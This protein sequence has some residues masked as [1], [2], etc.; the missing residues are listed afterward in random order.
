MPSSRMATALFAAPRNEIRLETN[1]VRVLGLAEKLWERCGPAGPGGPPIHLR[2]DVRPGGG[3]GPLP[4]KEI[5]WDLGDEEYAASVA[6]VLSLRIALPEARVNAQLSDGLLEADPS[7]VTRTLLEAPT[8][9]LL[10]RRGFAALHAGA[11]VGPKGAVVLRGAGGA[12]KSTLVAAAWRDGLGVLA[13]ESILVSREDP[14]LLAAS[15]RELTLLPDAASLLSLDGE[16]VEAFAGGE[17]KRRVDLLPGSTPA[18]RSARRSA[19]LLLG[20]RVPGPARF[21]ALSRAEFLAAFR[22][23][24][25]PQEEIGGDPGA[26]AS[27]WAGSSS[28]RLDGAEDLAG[29]VALLR[30]LVA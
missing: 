6:E 20:S 29:A 30:S 3:G 26:I 5:S 12:G 22:E 9:V 8:A 25:I 11:V 13:D 18:D 14:G 23:G 15:V 24:E 1:D 10:C 4:E 16:T 27:A 17:P 7:F 28:W 21:V 19:T 2:V